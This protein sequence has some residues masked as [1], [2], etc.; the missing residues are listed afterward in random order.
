MKK[1]TAKDSK[2]AKESMPKDFFRN[3]LLG[4]LGVLGGEKTTSSP[5]DCSVERQ[6]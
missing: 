5:S 4:N 3:F 1:F 2:I 6:E